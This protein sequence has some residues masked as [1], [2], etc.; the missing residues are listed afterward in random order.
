MRNHTY[1]EK[2]VECITVSLSSKPVISGGILLLVE[3]EEAHVIKGD[4]VEDKMENINHFVTPEQEAVV[5][6]ESLSTM[7]QLH[8]FL[9]FF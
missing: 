3:T 6:K 9:N 4:D 2:H 8:H 7:G 5:V 1:K